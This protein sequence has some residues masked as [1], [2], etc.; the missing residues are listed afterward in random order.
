MFYQA[1]HPQGILLSAKVWEPLPKAEV[2]KVSAVVPVVLF[3]VVSVSHPP[4]HPASFRLWFA[5]LLGNIFILRHCL[6]FEALIY[7]VEK[8]V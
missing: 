1:P 8:G 7:Y 3:R 4:P 5:A 6:N 2:G